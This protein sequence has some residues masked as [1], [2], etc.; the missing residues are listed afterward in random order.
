MKM[1]GVGLVGEEVLMMDGLV[2]EKVEGEGDRLPGFGGKW[3]GGEDVDRWFDPLVFALGI[4]LGDRWASKRGGLD[5]VWIGLWH[6]DFGYNN[7]KGPVWL[8]S[9]T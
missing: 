8:D 9:K 4:G 7:T 1:V 3:Y 2:G 5:C 6:W